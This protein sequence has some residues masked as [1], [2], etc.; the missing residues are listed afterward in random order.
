MLLI[1]AATACGA[2]PGLSAAPGQARLGS[3]DDQCQRAA[4]REVRID[5]DRPRDFRRAKAS[6]DRGLAHQK[7]GRPAEA[8]AEFNRAIAADATFGLAHLEAAVSHLYTDND[9]DELSAHLSAAVVLLPRN[10]RAQLQY[11][12]F[13]R[14]VGNL[15]LAERH[16]GCAL[17]LAPTHA[18]THEALARLLLVQDRAADAEARARS[19]VALAPTKTTYRVLLADILTRRQRFMEA[20]VE[21]EQ[22]AKQVGRSAALYRRAAGLYAQGGATTDAARLRRIADKL[23]PPRQRRRLRPLKPGR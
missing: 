18:P 12:R 8:L 17:A 15:D 22:A 1:A 11:A 16:L 14:E 4:V 20:G 6:F 3:L 5:Q 19:A 21:V 10:P 13:Q 23:D 7:A 9:R 2:A